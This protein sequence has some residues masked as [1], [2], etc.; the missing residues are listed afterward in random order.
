MIT[1]TA[2]TRDT[3]DTLGYIR[4]KGLMPA[5]FYGAKNESTVITVD[6]L[7]FIKAL[8]E[9][10]ESTTVVLELDGKKI[11]T[12][13]H[14]V[15]VDPVKRTPM[16]A[17]FLTV[18]TNKPVTVMVPLEFIGVS[19]SVKQGLGTVVKV[20]HEIEIEALPHDL[21]H[22][23]EVDIS[24]LK[25]TEDQIT[26]LDL[27]LPKGVTL[28]SDESEI[29]AIIAEQK[30]EVETEVVDINSIEVEKKGKQDEVEE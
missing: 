17:D 24:S 20:I 23:I 11:T 4:S 25:T 9:A 21:P 29:V 6:T 18:D 2:K 30:E 19:E 8:K 27:V 15:Q 10:G 12:L 5:V 14:D 16:H 28:K 7:S 3:K 13:I 1:L 22:M 26:T